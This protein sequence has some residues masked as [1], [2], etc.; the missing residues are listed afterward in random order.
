MD[1]QEQLAAYRARC[2]RRQIRTVDSSFV[3]ARLL[4]NNK[5]EEIIKTNSQ[6]YIFQ[7]RPNSPLPLF[8]SHLSTDLYDSLQ[9]L[10]TP[11]ASQNLHQSV[12]GVTALQT[13]LVHPKFN[14][15]FNHVYYD[16]LSE[17]ELMRYQE[18]V[19]EMPYEIPVWDNWI[20]SKVRVN[21]DGKLEMLEPFNNIWH[22]PLI[23]HLKQVFEGVFPLMEKLSCYPDCKNRKFQ[24]SLNVT[25]L[26]T[27]TTRGRGEVW[28]NPRSYRHLIQPFNHNKAD[29]TAMYVLSC[30][31]MLN[32][33]AQMKSRSQETT[34][35]IQLFN[36]SVFI[37]NQ[38]LELHRALWRTPLP[39]ECFLVRFDI[40]WALTSF[41][42]GL[43]MNMRPQAV[44]IC[45]K[46]AK[47]QSIS[48][49][50]HIEEL[51][52]NFLLG[53]A[54]SI[55]QPSPC[56]RKHAHVA[57]PQASSRADARSP[58]HQTTSTRSPVH[59]QPV[60]HIRRP[61]PS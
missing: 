10:Y 7:Q 15:F 24:L 41:S 31:D 11:F 37:T 20:P 4:T 43:I 40:F 13:N 35:E 23:N 28:L 59:S 26:E 33:F 5:D 44:Q 38:H 12:P 54:P 39:C 22:Q 47:E 61:R 8:P 16:P 42:D 50:S 34:T 6:G 55:E 9:T 46:W 56:K 32:L 14:K 19:G 18:M 52:C 3:A 58:P 21:N 29:L 25:K 57:A 53:V 45:K 1:W 36:Q 60:T 30:D 2:R 27:A 17:E 48:I 49:G 51:V